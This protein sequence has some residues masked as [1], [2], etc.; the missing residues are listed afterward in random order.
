MKWRCNTR[1]RNSVYMC[2]FVCLCVL[3][4]TI[5][6]KILLCVPVPLKIAVEVGFATTVTLKKYEIELY[7]GPS[8][9]RAVNTLRLGYKHQSN[10]CLFS[11]PYL[12]HKYSVW[13][14]RRIFRRICKITKASISFVMSVRPSFCLHS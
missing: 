10:C 7:I 1:R 12:T 2:V 9:Y 8:P 14:E 5:K 3:V 11:D 13:A 4:P 6:V